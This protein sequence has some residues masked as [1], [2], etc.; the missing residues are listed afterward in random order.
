GA[1]IEELVK[2]AA[3]FTKESDVVA[4]LASD[5]GGA[6]IVAAVGDMAL[7]NGANSGTLVREMSKIVG[8]GGGGRA[9]L[10]QG[11]GPDSG[12]ID[13]ALGRGMEVLRESLVR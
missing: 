8:G 2:A 7:E 3:E 1:D 4:L 9:E 12:K 6:K 11:G 5:Q 10:A 13:E